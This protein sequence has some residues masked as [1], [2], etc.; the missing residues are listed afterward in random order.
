M[1]KG[2][3]YFCTDSDGHVYNRYSKDHVAPRFVVCTLQRVAGETASKGTCSYSSK[4]WPLS[5][6]TSVMWWYGG[7][8]TVSTEVVAVR[9]YP[10]RHAIEPTA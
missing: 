2:I 3:T 1:A 9:A 4:P 6:S 5:V 7:K 10:G 8:E